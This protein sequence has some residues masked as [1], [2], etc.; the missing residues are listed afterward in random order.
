MIKHV[1]LFPQSWV[2]RDPL[3]LL[4]QALSIVQFHASMLE[5]LLLWNYRPISKL[6]SN[7][8]QLIL[9]RS[10]EDFPLFV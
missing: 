10:P 6:D 3:A 1:Y 7:T 2:D 9:H 5:S 8:I 4:L